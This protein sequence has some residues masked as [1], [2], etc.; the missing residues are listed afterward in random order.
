[1]TALAGLYAITVDGTRGDTLYSQVESAL[2]GGA[3]ILQYRDK[4]GDTLRRLTE[5]KTLLQLCDAHQ[6]LLIINDDIELCRRSGAHGV[7]L[8]KE[9]RDLPGAR[10][11]LGKDSIIGVSCYN[12]L[13]RARAA[14]DQG[15]DYVAFGAVYRS[16]TKP[17]AVNA[18]LAL[19]REARTALDLPI[20][21]IGGITPENA[22]PVVEAGADMVAMI[23]GL[24]GQEDIYRAAENTSRLFKPF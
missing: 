3:C 13:Q 12:D 23:Q 11:I 9:D 14:A 15:A 10:K 4:S 20:V 19:L 22:L 2:A 7:H 16:S 5:A 18:G 21:A 1:M 17:S 8:G 6:A 24:F